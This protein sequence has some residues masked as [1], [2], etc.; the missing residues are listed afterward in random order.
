ML[1]V[2]QL[3]QLQY[4]E[5]AAAHCPDPLGSGAWARVSTEPLQRTKS[6]RK[7]EVSLEGDT[8]PTRTDTH[9]T[10]VSRVSLLKNTGFGESPCWSWSSTL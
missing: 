1:L 10:D 8:V 7:P 3:A 2:G 4:T 5:R 6:F 9:G